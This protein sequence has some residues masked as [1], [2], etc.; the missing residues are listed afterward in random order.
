MRADGT[1]SPTQSAHRQASAWSHRSAESAG[2]A[3]VP[4]PSSRNLAR[5]RAQSLAAIAAA[6]RPDFWATRQPRHGFEY[7]RARRSSR[8]HSGRSVRRADSNGWR[9]N[10]SASANCTELQ[11][12]V[13]RIISPTATTFATVC[14]P[15]LASMGS[16][17]VEQRRE[18]KHVL[19]CEVQPNAAPPRLPAQSPAI[20][21][22]RLEMGQ[23]T[24]VT[25]MGADLNSAFRSLTNL[26]Q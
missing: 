20:A 17:W 24:P 8:L 18:R 1:L 5:S 21:I 4:V 6:R 3:S 19:D 13:G 26:D 7:A 2:D 11:G 16:G 9:G 22:S 23:L 25:R 14:A 15:Q 10:A 12:Q